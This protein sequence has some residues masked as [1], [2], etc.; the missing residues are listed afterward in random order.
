MCHFGFD[1]AWSDVVSADVPASLPRLHHQSDDSP[2]HFAA[3]HEVHFHRLVPLLG[4]QLHLKIVL[5]DAGVVDADF[6]GD[7]LLEHSLTNVSVAVK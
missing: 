4:S 7:E 3:A 5:G 2:V 6:N 1:V